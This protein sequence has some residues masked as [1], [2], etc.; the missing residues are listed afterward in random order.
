MGRHRA[1]RRVNAG[2]GGA[3]DAIAIAQ[4]RMGR[5]RTARRVNAGNDECA[6][7]LVFFEPWKGDTG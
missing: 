5:H 6:I 3:R 1:A 2:T 7:T 4:P